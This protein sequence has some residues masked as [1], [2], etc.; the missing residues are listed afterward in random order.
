MSKNVKCRILEECV[1]QS[2]TW[3]SY[4]QFIHFA[5]KEESE[6]NVRNKSPL[7][8]DRTSQSQFTRNQKTEKQKKKNVQLFCFY[9]ASPQFPAFTRIIIIILNLSIATQLRGPG[10]YICLKELPS[11]TNTP[12]DRRQ[13]TYHSHVRSKCFFFFSEC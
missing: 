11:E 10:I 12:K 2:I 13:N 8:K 9:S 3:A 7:S 1:H 4:N 5:Q 6:M